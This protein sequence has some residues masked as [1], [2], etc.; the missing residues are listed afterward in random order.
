M[1]FPIISS[2]FL[3][4]LFSLFFCLSSR[5]WFGVWLGLELNIIS[6]IVLAIAEKG[7]RNRE[8]SIKYFLLQALGR[9]I[10]FIGF[11]LSYLLKGSWGL[12]IEFDF[13]S[14]LILIGLRIK[15]GVAPF[16]FWVPSVINALGW[17]SAL[18]LSTIQKIG[19]LFFLLY[20]S[21]FS[22]RKR[23]II[24]SIIR[25]VVGGRGGLNQTQV[26]A[27]LGY[28]SIRHIGWIIR[29]GIVSLYYSLSY[30]LIYFI[31]AIS[32]FRVLIRLDNNKV[33]NFYFKDNI[34][35]LIF[36]LILLSLGGLPPLL[37]FFPKMIAFN[38]LIQTDFFLVLFVLITGSLI[39]LFYYLRLFF[40]SFLNRFFFVKQGNVLL[41]S[42]AHIL[43]RLIFILFFFGSIFIL[44]L[45][46]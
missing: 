46:Y 32:L 15:L 31:R 9:G 27:L 40:N 13:Q 5:N 18:V 41:F 29:I 30:F 22:L 16:H 2:F 39:R 14:L 38:L 4:L 20:L 28:S 37:G 33:K 8:A 10:L 26:R 34:N 44:E 24:I 7:L 21:S 1:Y 6:F 17:E 25:V 35:I 12:I 11:T 36:Y 3:I 19:P 43:L 45:I 42:G 23:L